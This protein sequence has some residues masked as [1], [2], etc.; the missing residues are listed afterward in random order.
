MKKL[1]RN[2]IIA[3]VLLATGILATPSFCSLRSGRAT[4]P[5]GSQ[6]CGQR[7]LVGTWEGQVTIYD[8]S[9]GDIQRSFPTMLTFGSQG[10]L[11]ETPAGSPPAVRGPGHGNW[12]ATGRDTY[13]AIFKAF[14]FNPAGTWVGTQTVVQ[15][16]QLEPSGQFTSSASIEIA[17]TEGNVL[18]TACATAVARRLE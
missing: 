15:E 14:L 1:T 11:I 17:D 16:I 13:A 7:D 5:D 3:T 6:S 18:S 9:A 4:I 10:T 8:C 12:H 2:C